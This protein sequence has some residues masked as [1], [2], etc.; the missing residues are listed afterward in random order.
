[1]ASSSLAAS[2]LKQQL[3]CTSSA[4]P[5]FTGVPDTTQAWRRHRLEHIT[6]A[7]LELAA[8]S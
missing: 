2:K 3:T 1:M 8:T 7:A 6:A 5:R 4:F